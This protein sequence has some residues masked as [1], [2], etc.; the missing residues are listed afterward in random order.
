M[1]VGVG[2]GAGVGG[3]LTPG[4]RCNTSNRFGVF[5]ISPDMRPT[6]LSLNSHDATASGVAVRCTPR[7]AAAAPAT[8]G[9]DIE[10]PD[11]LTTAASLTI[12]A[13]GTLMP[14]ALR[15]TH[16]PPL[17]NEARAS[18]PPLVEAP[19]VMAPGARAGETVQ[20][21]TFEFPAA[22]TTTMPAARIR[23]TSASMTVLPPEKP[24]LRLATIGPATRRFSAITQSTPRTSSSDVPDPV[25]FMTRTSSSVALGAVPYVRPA[26]SEATSVP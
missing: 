17:E 3:A 4:S 8:S 20:A 5:G 22:T 12:P 9:L 21:L 1:G 16:D 11:A 7:Y 19:T 13:P 23:S 24:R 15:S 18:T 6:A 25:A 26:A 10:V 2:A 14:G